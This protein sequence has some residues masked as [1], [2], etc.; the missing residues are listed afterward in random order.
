MTVLAIFIAQALDTNLGLGQQITL[1]LILLPRKVTA[2]VTRLIAAT[3]GVTGN[4]VQE[5]IVVK[6]VIDLAFSDGT[7]V[8]TAGAVQ[9]VRL[10][11]RLLLR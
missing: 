4:G 1:L 3:E 10:L 7:T 5:Q 6:V 8:I 9:R 11:S 2:A